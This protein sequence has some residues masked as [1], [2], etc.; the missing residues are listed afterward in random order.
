MKD[1][2]EQRT[3]VMSGGAGADLDGRPMEDA[4]RTRFADRNKAVRGIEKISDGYFTEGFDTA[5]SCSVGERGA[6]S[7]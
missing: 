6:C 5:S 3:S 7:S 1:C 4:D 2:C